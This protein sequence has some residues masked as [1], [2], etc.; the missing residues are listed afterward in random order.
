MVFALDGDVTATDVVGVRTLTRSY[1]VVTDTYTK[2]NLNFE[3]VKHANCP[4]I[5]LV[6]PTRE[7]HRLNNNFIINSSCEISL[8]GCEVCTM[9]WIAIDPGRF[10]HGP[11]RAGHGGMIHCQ[12][13]SF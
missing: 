4:Y 12:C 10:S 3:S 6:A 8:T 5:V 7:S 11:G 13:S 2:F 9:D 1:R